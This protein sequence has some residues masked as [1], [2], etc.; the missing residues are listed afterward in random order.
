MSLSA[1]RLNQ[2][3][4]LQSKVVAR[5]AMGGEGASTWA[6]GVTVWAGVEPLRMREYISARAGQVD[7]DCRIIMRYRAGLRAD[8]RV[9]HGDAIYEILE[10]VDQGSRK[11][12]LEL[13]CSGPAAS[14]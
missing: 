14:T 6:D 12:V 5:D 7:I 4:T 2:R 11:T 3:V 13:L 10:I 9:R 1:G 8:M